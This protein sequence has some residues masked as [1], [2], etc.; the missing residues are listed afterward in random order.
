MGKNCNGFNNKIGGNSKIAKALDIKDK[1]NIDY[2][3]Y[4]EHSIDFRHK[5]NKNDLKQM[6]QQEL[7][8]TAVTAQNIHKD[9]HA[10]RVHEGGTGSICFGDA[11]GYVKKVGRNNKGLGGWCWILLGG[12][13]GHNTRIITAY[14]PCK[15]KN[16]NSGTTYQ[17][18]FR[19]FITKKKNLTCPL[20][21]FCRHLIKLIKQWHVA[22]DRIVLFMDHNK[23][24]IDGHL[25]KALADKDSPDLSKAIK[26][27]TGASP[28]ATFF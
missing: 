3:L 19:Y 16:I 6:F 11:S 7:A 12:A 22:G 23:H 18:Q 5:D 1:L 28:G 10:G 25:G 9:R 27:H 21:L 20:I 13:E 14:N 17:Q 24:T 26:L 2:L 4:C 8:C 15:N